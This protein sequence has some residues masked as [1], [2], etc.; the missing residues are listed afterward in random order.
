M[1]VGE[2]KMNNPQISVIVP[3][4]NTAEYLHKCIYSIRNQSYKNLEI[5]LVNDGSTD[6]SLDICNKFAE[7]DKRIIIIDKENGGVSSARNAGLDIASGDYIG[8]VDSDDYINP[9]MYRQLIEASLE[10]DAD[11]AECG[12]KVIKEDFNTS[13]PVL[14]VNDVIIGNYECS[15]S[16][17]IG[18][19]T[20]NANWNKLYRRTI[21]D[22]IRF[23]KYSYTEDFWV[24]AKAFYQ[25]QRKVTIKDCYYYYLKHKRS[26]SSALFSKDRLHSILSRKDIFKFYQTRFDDLCPYIALSIVKKITGLYVFLKK[27]GSKEMEKKYFK[28]LVHEYKKYYPLLDKKVYDNIRFTKKHIVLLL[29]HIN[30]ELYYLFHKIYQYFK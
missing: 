21:F 10:N 20:K 26:A 1:G 24:N 23:P 15:K 12:Y 13:L 7:N 5:I 25:C 19:N 18:Q 9:D 2:F 17:L 16:F 14:F 3:I 27:T 6:N 8:F 28:V 22:G 30:P 4:F 11:I 29:F